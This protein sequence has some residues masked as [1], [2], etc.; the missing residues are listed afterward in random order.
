LNRADTIVVLICMD[1]SF[2]VLN[3]F[4]YEL[5]KINHFRGLSLNIVQMFSKQV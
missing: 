1:Q 2:D 4:R 5:I 3:L